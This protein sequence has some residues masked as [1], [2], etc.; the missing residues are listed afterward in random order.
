MSQAAENLLDARGV[1]KSFD[2]VLVNKDI[3]FGLASGD[4]VAL[5][6]PNGAGKTTFVNLVAG[7]IMPSAGSVVLMGADVTALG[8]PERVRR[9]LVRTFQITRLFG[10]LT[11]AENVALAVMQRQALTRRFLSV[12]TDTPEIRNEWEA[13]LVTLGIEQLARH[14][15]P[16]LAY[17]QQRLVEI[18]VGL[19][20]KPKVL[21][22]DEPG[23]GVPQHESYRILEAINRLPVDI[24]VL[25]IEHDM[26]MVFRFAQRVIVLAN[27]R[28][29]FEGSPEQVSSDED[30][31]KAY[32]GS[33][34][35]ARSVA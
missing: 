2:G 34:A 7:N 18:A 22:L 33:F 15:V 27:G 12:L 9:G 3:S 14:R 26:D 13:L 32:L 30:V 1:S 6:G 21:L 29:I 20:L 16:E 4:R 5:I 10:S 23:A 25:M 31:R 11:V 17:G 19:A 35:R 8:V 28:I 24:A